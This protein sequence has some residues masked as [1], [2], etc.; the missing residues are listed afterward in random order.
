MHINREGLRLV[1]EEEAYIGFVYDDLVEPRSATDY[2]REWK[3][4]PPR[5]TLTIGYGTTMPKSRVTQGNRIARATAEQWLAE[6]M[7]QAE[8]DVTRLVKVPLNENQFSALVSFVYNVGPGA[9]QSS[10]L[11]RLLNAGNYDAVPRE[12]NK[13]VLSKGQRLKGLVRRRAR[14][15]ALWSKPAP[16][17]DD[18]DDELAETSPRLVPTE[19]D[20]ETPLATV[21]PDPVPDKTMGRSTIGN[22]AKVGAGL[23]VTGILSTVWEHISEAPAHAWDAIEHL[24][25]KPSFWIVGGVALAF[26]F[27]Y[28]RRDLMHKNQGV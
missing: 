18:V 26:A 3:G 2:E 25:S 16:Q 24:T 28:W 27:I 5:G 15:G 4:G 19:I 23:T 1:E 21:E 22:G 13:Y 9:L 7:R 6:D 11:L 20:P 17:V 8:A 10:T 12:L 14:E